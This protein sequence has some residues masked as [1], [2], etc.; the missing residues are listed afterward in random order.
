MI[1]GHIQLPLKSYVCDRGS[2]DTQAGGHGGLWGPLPKFK[3]SIH[4]LGGPG[5][6]GGEVGSVFK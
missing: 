4:S 3:T 1:L 2:S 6:V 5:A